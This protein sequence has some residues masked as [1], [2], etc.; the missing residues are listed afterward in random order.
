MVIVDFIYWLTIA[1]LTQQ[2][3]LMVGFLL[4]AALIKGAWMLLWGIVYSFLVG[5]FPPIAFY[6]RSSFTIECSND[7]QKLA[8]HD[9]RDFFYGY[10]LA[11]NALRHLTDWD[12][13]WF[14]AI[15]LLLGLVILHSLLTK[16]YAR[17]G[18]SRLIAWYI[19]CIPFSIV[20]ALLPTKVKQ[21]LKLKSRT[22]IIIARLF[23]LSIK[24]F[25]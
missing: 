9:G 13:R 17:Y 6:Y 19:L 18:N 10:P 12:T 20:A 23:Q 25:Y 15:S 21:R 24:L 2:L 11:M 3:L 5:L 1:T 8:R 14:F 16:I 4:I 22:M 7:R